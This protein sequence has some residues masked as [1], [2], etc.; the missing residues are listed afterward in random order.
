MNQYKV[1]FWVGT[2]R[3]LALTMDAENEL[4][5]LKNALTDQKQPGKGLSW[6]NQ[7]R[8]YRIEIALA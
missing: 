7:G 5:A 8:E 1:V 3:C 4:I 2:K 6:L